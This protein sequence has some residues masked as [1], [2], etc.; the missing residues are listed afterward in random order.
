MNLNQFYDVIVIGAGPAG[1]TAAAEL[2]ASGLSL[3]ILEKSNLPRYKCCGG[4]ITYKTAQLLPPAVRA[5]FEDTIDTFRLSLNGDSLFENVSAQPLM[6]T[7]RRDQLDLALVERATAGGARLLQNTPVNRVWQNPD[8]VEVE[9]GAGTWRARFVIGADGAES[10]TAA[11]VGLLSGTE[12]LVAL[13][14]EVLVAASDLEKWRSRAALDQGRISGGY[15]WVFPKSDHLSIGLVSPPDQAKKLRSQYQEYQDSLNLAGPVIERLSGA[16]IPVF[17]APRPVTKGRVALVG[18][19]AGLADPITGEGIYNAV[20]SASLAATAI[21]QALPAGHS[22]L[23]LYAALVAEKIIPQLEVAAMY[24]HLLVRVPRPIL[25]ML[26]RDSR[27]WAN[28]C[29]L[30]RGERDYLDIH[31]RVTTL[32][33]LS[34]LV[35]RR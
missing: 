5:C 18:D 26:G 22:D 1:A 9:T 20:V 13:E 29:H 23:S 6:Y 28:F 21:R 12:N 3:L 31:N 14:A 11:Q 30:L 27:V 7:V 33:G 10:F 32:G 35:F 34:Q 16:Q 24:S 2:A 19:A 8:D 25:K 15:A 4:G 17:R